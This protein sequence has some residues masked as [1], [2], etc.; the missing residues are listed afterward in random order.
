MNPTYPTTPDVTLKPA[1]TLGEKRVRVSFNP[2]EDPT[3]K[4]IKR[5]G[6]QLI[7]LCET[8][9][10]LDPRAA[11]IAQTE[12]ESATRWTVYAATTPKN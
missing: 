8:L 6:A 1:Q 2:S 4:E 5:L 7:D 9:K 10:P 12:F 3:V 11:S